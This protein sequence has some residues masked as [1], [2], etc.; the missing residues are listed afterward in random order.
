M[1]KLYHF[2]KVVEVDWLTVK[3]RM[4]NYGKPGHTQ[5]TY[6]W[7]LILLHIQKTDSEVKMR[8]HLSV[9]SVKE[10]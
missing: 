6:L 8:V 7:F 4:R 2:E 3:M 1:Y 5:T 10:I 9:Y